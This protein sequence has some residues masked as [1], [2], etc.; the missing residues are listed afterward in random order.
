MQTIWIR[1]D[2]SP[3]SW[4][5]SVDAYS[6]C[7]G[8][9]VHRCSLDHNRYA[10]THVATGLAACDRIES[11]ARA[12]TIMRA[13][14]ESG[15]PWKEIKSS[16]DATPYHARFRQIVDSL[17]KDEADKKCR[18]NRKSTAGSAAAS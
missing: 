4:R 16:K 11:L 3:D 10:V 2:E 15:I 17:T 6:I 5:R 14:V 9:A 1:A 13:L 7:G 18:K 12:R 8:L